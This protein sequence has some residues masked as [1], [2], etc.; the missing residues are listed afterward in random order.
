MLQTFAGG[1]MGSGKQNREVRK[2]ADDNLK[3]FVGILS[4]FER[5]E[6]H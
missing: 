5:Q 4:G 3:A 1:S 6:V 2:E